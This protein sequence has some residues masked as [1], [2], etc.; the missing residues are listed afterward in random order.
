MQPDNCWCSYSQSS[1]SSP[2]APVSNT[3]ERLLLTVHGLLRTLSLLT[4]CVPGCICDHIRHSLLNLQTVHGLP[5]ALS[6]PHCL[7]YTM[8]S[9]SLTSPWSRLGRPFPSSC[10]LDVHGVVHRHHPTTAGAVTPDRQSNTRECLL[11]TVRGLLH[12][13]SLLTYCVGLPGCLY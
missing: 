10:S 12:T 2:R 7:W 13:L 4:C 6:P 5:P 8:G 11:L 1:P 9:V 3:W